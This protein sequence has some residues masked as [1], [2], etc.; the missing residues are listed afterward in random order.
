LGIKLQPQPRGTLIGAG[1][2]ETRG[3]RTGAG[4]IERTRTVVEKEK[5][6]HSPK[7]S[8]I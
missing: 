8:S 5:F 4:K 2:I 3:M 1:K 6:Y 7:K